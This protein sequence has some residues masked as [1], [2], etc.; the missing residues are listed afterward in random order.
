VGL[1]LD[2]CGRERWHAPQRPEAG[3]PA[4]VL[5][6]FTGDVVTFIVVGEETFGAVRYSGDGSW[7]ERDGVN[8]DAAA[9]MAGE[10]SELACRA[11]AALGLDIAEVSIH[12]GVSPPSVVLC[13][14]GPDLVAWNRILDGR[15]AAALAD[16]FTSVASKRKRSLT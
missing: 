13:E 8:G 5:E 15:L 6:P 14:A 16:H 2:A 11:A 1:V 9:G 4:L 12:I 7:A 10:A 3:E